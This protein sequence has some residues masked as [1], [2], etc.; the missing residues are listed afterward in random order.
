MSAK[1]KENYKFKN[2]FP[3][4]HIFQIF[5]DKK[6]IKLVTVSIQKLYWLSHD[7]CKP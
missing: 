2:L 3:Y 4:V 7:L 6:N 5:L 1:I